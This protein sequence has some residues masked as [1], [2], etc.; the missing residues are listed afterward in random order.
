V[1]L[2]ASAG[3]TSLCSLCLGLSLLV[4]GGVV[5][6]LCAWS[7]LVCVWSQ[8]RGESNVGSTCTTGNTVSVEHRLIKGRLSFCIVS[9]MS[10]YGWILTLV[11]I[12]VGNPQVYRIHWLI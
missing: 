11:T 7:L 2:S 12:V 8:F 9:I 10:G 4:A 6:W 1:S 5:V 3:K